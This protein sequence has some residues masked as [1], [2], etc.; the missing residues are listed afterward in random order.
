LNVRDR[1]DGNSPIAWAGHGSANA[2]DAD[3]DHLAIVDLLLDAGSDRPSSFN[4][5]GEPPEILA[6][7]A[8]ADHLGGRGF[9]SAE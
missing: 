4:R 6:S 2:R 5:S 9:A 8:V 7:E 3:E 1:T